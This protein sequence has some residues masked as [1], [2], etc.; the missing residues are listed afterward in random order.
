MDNA[1]LYGL[2]AE[3]SGADALSDATRTVLQNG[4][5]HVEAYS[6]FPIED[7]GAML[8]ADERGIARWTFY[9]GIA[10][11]IGA[12]FLQWYS[13]VVDYPINV[14]GRPLHSW[15]AFI[16]ITF[17]MA[18]LGAAVAAIAGMLRRSGLPRL[19]HPLFAAR[20]FELAS[21]NRFFLVI[22]S[23]DK[24]FDIE[25]TQKF[26]QSLQPL[27]IGEVKA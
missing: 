27:R 5:R 7:L 4:Y 22:K 25:T 21:R 1:I 17:E 11:G 23:D 8:G 24:Q 18:V 3:F 26:L 19:R 14:G 6:P 15:P 13:A 2:L 12:Y 10:G 20:D 16:P 9:G